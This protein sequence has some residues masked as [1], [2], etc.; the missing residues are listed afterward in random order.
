MKKDIHGHTVLTMLLN[1]EEPLSRQDLVGMI[2]GEFGSDVC[3]HTCSQQG[4]TLT[5]LLDFL[6]SK[7]KIVESDSG[8]TVNPDRVCHH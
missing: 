6:L 4:L 5:Q 3:F 8:L 1:S 7:Q 2:E